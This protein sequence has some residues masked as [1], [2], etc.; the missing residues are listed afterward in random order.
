MD[1]RKLQRRVGMMVLLT[2]LSLG[3]MMALFGQMPKLIYG[4]YKLYISFV[5]A[6]GVGEGTPVRKS[7]ILIGRVSKVRFSEDD[8]QVEVIVGIQ[9]Q[10]HLRKNEICRV[11][12]NILGDASLEFVR[13]SNAKPTSEL[14]Q[15]GDHLQGRSA[16]EPT[17]I[18]SNI[19]D[20][21]DST[22][23]SVQATSNNLSTASRKLTTTLDTLNGILEENKSGI[24]NV[25]NSTN[26]VMGSVQTIIGDKDTQTQLRA[27]I[28]EM[29][30]MI[31]DTHDTVLKMRDTIHI[32]DNN[33]RNAEAFTKSLGERGPNLINNLENGTQKLDSL[34]SQMLQFSETLNNSKGTI[35]QLVNN[36]ELYQHLNQAAKNIDEVS[37]Q[38]KPIVSDARV[39][40]DKIARHPEML[41]V[42]GVMQKGAGIK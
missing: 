25:V 21:F 20:K 11:Q 37:R 26:D 34:V 7:G 2:L 1:E 15:N 9:D 38:L 22:I 33:M 32:V 10:Y 28:K 18:I 31:A 16:A 17:Q 5:Q 35:G 42:K 3:I 27:A 36:P 40:S 4:E 6:P 30:Q 14:Y 41:G 29:P 12:S 13:A 39:F 8:S 19:Q 24:K 23:E